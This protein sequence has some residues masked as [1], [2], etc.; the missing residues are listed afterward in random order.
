MKKFLICFAIFCVTF[1]CSLF[2]YACGKTAPSDGGEDSTVGSD[3]ENG[4]ADSPDSDKDGSDVDDN[5]DIV[6]S[7]TFGEWEIVVTPDCTE[8]GK[9][10]RICS[11]GE[12]QTEAIDALGHVLTDFE[13][14]EAT[15]L[16][17]GWNSYSAC[18]RCDYTTYEEIPEKGH[19]FGKWEITVQ[20]TCESDGEQTRTC[21]HDNS[22]VERITI[23]KEGHVDGE[24]FI[25]IKPTCDSQGEERTECSVCNKL[26]HSHTLNALGHNYGEW[27]TVTKANCV[28]EGKQERICLNDGEHKQLRTVEKTLHTRGEWVTVVKES[29]QSDGEEN[30]ICTVCKAVLETREVKKLGHDYGEWIIAVKPDC[31]T[32]GL[33]KRICSRDEAHT[34]TQPVPANGH[35]LDKYLYDE[36]VHYQACQACGKLTENQAHNFED[37]N[38]TVCGYVNIKTQGFEFVLNTDGNTY[39]L[40]GI[41]NKTLSDITVP[42]NYNGKAVV[43][44]SENAFRSNKTITKVS[45]GKNIG[46]I[47]RGTFFGCDNLAE[48]SLPFLGGSIDNENDYIGY[49]FG[50]NSAIDN[51]AFLP[52]SLKKVSIYSGLTQIGAEAFFG[53]KSICEV[54]LP[55]TLNSIGE[56]A[57]RNCASLKSITLPESLTQI[58]ASAFFGCASLKK[59]TVPP[60]VNYI[61]AFAFAGTELTE[62]IFENAKGW[63]MYDTSDAIKFRLGDAL[64]NAV[65]AAGY[66]K[67]DR[68]INYIWKRG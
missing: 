57:F 38:C 25:S 9:R 27:K 5:E 62:V 56:R 18:S 20:A 7:H 67:D 33:K 16:Q 6:H 32:Q 22:H 8:D 35:S 10:T 51:G 11:C 21:A 23:E 14:K 52:V 49:A 46:I 4:W 26:L 12:K 30:V 63:A 50:A 29:C 43:G 41:S 2:F 59:L 47:A 34:E 31:T 61:G 39:T 42:E 24:P 37:G 55:D 58:C 45:V 53:C 28:Q 36:K 17:K 66:L 48:I 68:Y 54:V 15:C 44:I 19:S 60:K 1:C 3:T 64:E 65:F 13:A 40:T